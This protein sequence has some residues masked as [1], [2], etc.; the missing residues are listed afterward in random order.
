ML[1]G[2]ELG[3]T[4]LNQSDKLKSITTFPQLV[5][6]LRDE[7]DW[8]VS[9]SDFE[10]LTFEYTPEELGID[11][12]VAAKI[13]EIR[14]LRPLTA[15]QP[16]GIFFIKFEPKRL[17]VVALRRMLKAVALKKRATADSAERLSWDTEDLL[18]ISNYGEEDSR[19]ITFAQFSQNEE[20]KDLPTLKVL[21]WDNKDTVLHMD[22][23]AE[24]LNTYLTWPDDEDDTSAW[25]SSWR[26]AF[27][28]RH[29]EVIDTAKKLSVQLA[30]LAR[31][32]RER[33]NTVLDYETE[34]GPI[35]KLMNAF[36]EALVHDLDND[37]FADMY[38]QTIA[39]GLLSARIANP[40]SKTADGF[41]SAMPV[42]NPFLKELMETFIDVGG[43]EN[44]QKKSI[45]LD[46]DELGV[47]E[48]V[49]LLDNANMEAVVRDF[50]DKNPL[51]DPVTHFYEQF[52][53][54]YDSPER[55]KRGVFYTPRPVVSFIVRSVDE[56]LR[57]EFGLEDGLADITTWGEMLEYNENLVIPEGSTPDEAFVQILD[58]ATGTGTFLV[59][60]IDLVYKTMVM[61]WQTE[62]YIR[63]E[64]EQLWNSYVPEHL[65][66]RLHGYEL[67]M[68][69]YAIAHMK[70]GLKLYETGYHFKSE[71]RARVYLT[72]SLQPAQDFDEMLA[73]AIPALAHEAQAVNDIKQNQIF[74][75][76]IGNPPY[77]HMTANPNKDLKGIVDIYRKVDGETIRERG[78]IMF[79][80]TIQD[81]YVKFH[82][83]A[84][85]L[86][87][88]HPAIRAYI[89]NSAFLDSPTLRGMRWHLN[90]S[91]NE[92][93]LIDLHGDIKR[94][95]RADENVFDIRTGVAISVYSRSPTKHQNQHTTFK[96]I[97]GPRSKKYEFLAN[98]SIVSN[99]W[100]ELSPRT[101]HY[102]YRPQSGEDFSEL[103]NT[104]IIHNAF[105]LKSEAIK[106][107]RDHF[108][109]GSSEDE[110]MER[111][112]IFVDPEKTT[113][114]I[115]EEL[116]LKDNAQWSVESGRRECAGSFT[117][118][119]LTKIAYRPF[120]DK[121][122][123]YHPS[124]VFS[125]RPVLSENVHDHENLVFVTSRRI[126]TTK[127]AHFFVTDKIVIKEMLSSADNCNSYPLYRYEK[128]FA[129]EHKR[130]NFNSAF[131]SKLAE[132]LHLKQTGEYRTPEGL[133]PEDIF[134]YIY[135]IFHSPEYRNRYAEPLVIDFPVLPL[136]DKLVLFR[137]LSELGEELVGLHLLES[138]ILTEDMASP[139][140]KGTFLVEKISYSDE[141]VWVNKAMS[142]GF[143]GVP[144]DVWNFQIGSY[145]VCEK[146]LKDRQAKG[147]KNPR[148]GR[149]LS[150]D[151][152]EHYQ[153][154]I[155]AIS[156]TIRIMG[157]IDE[158]IDAHGGWPGAF[159]S[160]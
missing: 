42:T 106:T 59:E 44:K 12:K 120:D 57:T 53:A 143:S 33:I 32:I 126:R 45:R 86:I 129:E 149:V 130:T 41:A 125:P 72:N 95:E 27:T 153:K 23:V 30:H 56:L 96:E 119:H 6:Y 16:W 66:P 88:G 152:I 117:S 25:R 71:E 3:G 157:E 104:I 158:V 73:I 47:S 64:I 76:I 89:T 94:G 93:R 74:S 39:Y 115:K 63:R 24:S 133:T 147:G 92:I 136:T 54:D 60:V 159:Q 48:V 160:N 110:V 85:R 4:V 101:P 34:N 102:L 155:V 68:A 150:Q 46:F 19:Q 151:D 79:E 9:T 7:L 50:G 156:E 140:T 70:I 122:I 51:E 90:Q 5:K 124:V 135:S 13:Q 78:A 148:P 91:W 111:I 98:S 36:K 14:R 67:M 69:P 2:I 108:V 154:I 146:W 107:N 29:R 97:I 123:Y 20:K 87:E 17:P 109:I 84:D 132:S 134:Y 49:E 103:E 43:R 28:I 35:T 65:L 55:F 99:D 31:N 105:D 10:G 121:L 75:I 100:T 40:S 77:S 58:P 139:V 137:K 11:L 142:H 62:G 114:A 128:H 141:T 145:Q 26:S 18:F 113:E 112:R 61:K 81:D 118:S 1:D 37:G 15:N 83:L 138:P 116:H 8:P 52:F 80:R 22:H 82:A 144:D 38:A 131:L 21:G 127:H